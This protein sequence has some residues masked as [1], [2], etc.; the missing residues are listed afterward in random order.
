MGEVSKCQWYPFSNNL[1]FILNVDWFNPFKHVEYS[2]GVIYIVIANL[3]R[4]EHY[5]MENI[6]IVGVLPGPK[7]PK[8]HMNTYPKPLI[9]ELLELWNGT[10]L[11]APGIFIP[12]HCALLC[13]SCDLP[14][15]QKLC[16]FTTFSS[17][18]GCSK[19]MKKITCVCIFARIFWF[20]KTTPKRELVSPS[21]IHCNN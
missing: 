4:S 11:T 15:P 10:Y 7:E 13:V 12:I 19:C 3:P 17:L 21:Y 16:G 18:Q 14:A 20:L 1:R 8:K 5:K 6:L 9:D 2:V